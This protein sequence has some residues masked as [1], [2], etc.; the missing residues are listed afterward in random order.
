MYILIMKGHVTYTLKIVSGLKCSMFTATYTNST[1]YSPSDSSKGQNVW[2]LDT[3][4]KFSK[5][6]DD[7]DAL[8]EEEYDAVFSFKITQEA[9]CCIL[10]MIYSLRRLSQV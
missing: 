7:L 6:A 1:S 2:L 9:S 3:Y 10:Q 8:T 5:Y 4:G